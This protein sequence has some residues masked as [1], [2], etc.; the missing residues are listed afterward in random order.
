MNGYCYIQI[1]PEFD[2]RTNNSFER[3]M[4]DK[5]TFLFNLKSNGR[6][7]GPMKFEIIDCD[8]GKIEIRD[9]W[10]EELIRLGRITLYKQDTNLWHFYFELKGCFDD[11]GIKKSLCEPKYGND[12]YYFSSKRILV[13]QMK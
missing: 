3:K 5:N 11:H 7:N 6:L 2:F 8:L 10:N 9:D 12:P 4:V 13:I 1:D